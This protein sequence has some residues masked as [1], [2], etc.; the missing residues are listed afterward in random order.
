VAEFLRT[1][2][3]IESAPTTIKALLKCSF[4]E[5]KPGDPVYIARSDEVFTIN[6]EREGII[7]IEVC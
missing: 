4:P 5:W 2:K 1:Y 3:G 7:G 6:G